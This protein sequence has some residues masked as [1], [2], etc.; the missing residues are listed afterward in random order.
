M[1]AK[2]PYDTSASSKTMSQS[3][4]SSYPESQA[5][6]TSDSSAAAHRF[7]QQPQPSFVIGGTPY[8]FPSIFGVYRD[9]MRKLCL[10]EHHVSTPFMSIAVHSGLSGEPSIVLSS[11]T[12]VMGTA[13]LHTFSSK[14]ELVI[15]NTSSTLHS[16]GYISPVYDFTYT[17]DD[18]RQESF[19]WK[20]SSGAAVAGLGGRSKGYKLVRVS[21]GE[22][23]AAWTHPASLSIDK[24]AKVGL[25]DSMRA[26][27]W[28]ERWEV[29]LVLSAIALIEKERRARHS[30]AA[31]A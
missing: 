28:G 31:A 13:E 30:A 15:G 7:Q 14:V 3:F 9:G 5:P 18:G 25:L 4:T 12:A 17:F 22:V 29:T 20:R 11:P 10:A 27:S 16:S 1:S 6:S 26:L 23:L 8:L 2:T 19:Q 24:M 21:D